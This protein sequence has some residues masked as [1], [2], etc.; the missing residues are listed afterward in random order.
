MKNFKDDITATI[1]DDNIN[2]NIES[3]TLKVLYDS[4]KA[5]NPQF[6]LNTFFAS[7]A[8]KADAINIFI[9]LLEFE[10][11]ELVAAAKYD[12]EKREK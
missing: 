6:N 10:L 11:A 12:D 1:A 8:V 9:D 2:I 5:F 7:A 4:I 3:E